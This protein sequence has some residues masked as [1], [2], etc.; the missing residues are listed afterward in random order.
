MVRSLIVEDMHFAFK[1]VVDMASLD[2]YKTQHIEN[3]IS[4]TTRAFIVVS[5]QSS[6]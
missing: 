4:D 2:L 1:T 6:T 3:S 5:Y